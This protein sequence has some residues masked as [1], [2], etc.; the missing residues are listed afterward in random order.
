MSENLLE[1]SVSEHSSDIVYEQ[2]GTLPWRVNRHGDIEILLITSR[3]HKRWIV[4][5]GWLVSGRSQFLSAALE[6][7]Q[8][9]GVI[10]EVYPHP[11]GDYKYTKAWDDGTFQNRRVTLFS[12]HV[13][14][15]LINWPERADRKRRWVT[16]EE[17]LQLIA[18]PDLVRLL[19][20]IRSNT[21]ILTEL[22]RNHPAML[23]SN[24]MHDP[25]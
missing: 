14:G 21:G 19:Q 13:R 17:A 18:E 15:T 5:K 1:N 22:D 24:N 3:Q 10:G 4:P 25:S 20:K 2:Y 23:V 7:F 12:L 16:F 9:A 6:A 11:I 8:E